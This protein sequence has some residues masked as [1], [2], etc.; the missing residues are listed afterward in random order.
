MSAPSPVVEDREESRPGL[1]GRHVR[2]LDGRQKVDGSIEYTDDLPFEGYHAAIVRSS[3][4]H[5]RITGIETEA[6]EER[7]GVRAVVTGRDLVDADWVRP[8]TGPKVRDQPLLAI[9]RVRYVGEPVAAVVA[10]SR[11]IARAAAGDVAVDYDRLPVVDDIEAALDPDAPALHDKGAVELVADDMDPIYREAAPNVVFEERI[12]HGDVETGFDAADVVLEGTY[13]TAPIQ[14]VSL[15]SFA[16]IADYDAATDAFRIVTGSQMPHTVRTEVA[17]LFGLP[18]ARVEVEAP[19]MGGSYGSKTYVRLEPLTAA[20]SRAVKRPVKL[21]IT[22]SEAFDTT[23]RDATET[24]VRS[25]VTADG[26]ILAR[27][28]EVRWDTGAYADSGPGKAKKAAYTAPGAYEIENVSVTSTSV[29]TNKP[30]ATPYRGL[31][32][33]QTT[34]AVE[35]HTDELAD[36]IG[37]DPYE[38]RLSNVVQDGGTYNGDPIGSTGVAACLR[39]ATGEVGWLDR[40]VTQPEDAHL[41]R[42]RGL[43]IALKATKMPSTSEAVALLDT[44]ASLTI[45]S[46]SAKIGQGVQTTLAQLAA[47]ELGID[48]DSVVVRR[49]N[50]NEAPFNTSTTASRSTYAMGN[51]VLAAV[52]DIGSQAVESVAADWDVSP[53][54]LDVEDGAVTDGDRRVG[55]GEVVANRFAGGGGTLVGTGYE[56][57]RFPPDNPHGSA[58]WMAG[59]PSPR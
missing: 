29:Y 10:E 21:R 48:L 55:L 14:H 54:T 8:Y 58:F 52:D 27:E 9:D 39:A 23:I 32:V 36:A 19:Q 46:G 45:L 5:G 17:R 15:E 49:P 28:V 51:A 30:S 43:S 41:V 20:L 37:M 12:E 2:R 59:R 44:D 22:T 18:T 1:V 25:G 26:R 57:A 33:A 47:D 50:A 40:G 16:T 3:V 31:G 4:P 35:S 42:G 7:S 53:E 24:R 34:W 38:F 6:A 11:A 13:S 56:V